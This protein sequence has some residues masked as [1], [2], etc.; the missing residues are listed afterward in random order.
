MSFFGKHFY[1]TFWDIASVDVANFPVADG[2]SSYHRP[3]TWLFNGT[4]MNRGSRKEGVVCVRTPI[5]LEGYDGQPTK[6]SL[7]GNV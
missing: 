6:L 7:T 2:Q 5:G 3:A 1:T 4:R